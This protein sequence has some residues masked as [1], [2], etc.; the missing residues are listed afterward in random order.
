MITEA[1][2]LRVWASICIAAPYV[3]VLFILSLVWASS[4]HTNVKTKMEKKSFW[5]WGL[6]SVIKFALIVIRWIFSL[7][8][9][10]LIAQIPGA[11][12]N[13]A[14]WTWGGFLSRLMPIGGLSFLGGMF[15]LMLEQA[16]LK[17]AKESQ[18]LFDEEVWYMIGGPTKQI[19][20]PWAGP[21]VGIGLLIIGYGYWRE[22]VKA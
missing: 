14:T 1:E 16:I 2:W 10:Q 12:W 6:A 13:L 5:F 11:L 9:I 15:A 7:A 17:G 18:I 3:T 21:L 4:Y 19:Y 22:E 8:P 20:V